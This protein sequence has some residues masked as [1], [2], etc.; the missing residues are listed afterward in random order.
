M[1]K[2]RLPPE[3][4]ARELVAI[5]SVHHV[6]KLVL[7]SGCETRSRCL[8]IETIHREAEALPYDP[9]LSKDQQCRGRSTPFKALCVVF[10]P[11]TRVG[12]T[13][14]VES[15]SAAAFSTGISKRIS[16]CQSPK[17]PLDRVAF[18]RTCEMVTRCVTAKRRSQYPHIAPRKIPALSIHVFL[19]DRPCCERRPI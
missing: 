10:A 16:A 11:L 15:I 8:A 1:S 12:L 7:R 9:R 13:I 2:F 6:P 4:S 19:P 3:R 18:F 5:A 17:R 14:T